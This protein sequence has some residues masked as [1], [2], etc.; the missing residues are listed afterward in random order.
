MFKPKMIENENNL[1]CQNKHG[2]PVHLVV[3]DPKL[4]K[5][6]RLLCTECMENFESDAKTIGFKKIIQIIEDNIK[7][8]MSDLEGI[9][10]QTVQ[11]LQICNRSIQELK[12]YFM[13][14]FDSLISIVEDWTQNLFALTQQSKQY[15]FYDELDSFI[16][17]QNNINDSNITLIN[18]INRSW[19]AKL[20][21]ILNQYIQDKD[22]VNFNEQNKNLQT[23][24]VQF[25]HKKVKQNQSQLINLLNKVWDVKIQFLIL[26]GQLWYQLNRKILKYGA[27]QTEKFNQQTY[28]DTTIRCWKQQDS[29]DWISSQPYKQHT[30]FVICLLLNSNEDLL[31][32]GSDDKLIKVWKVDF[33]QNILT[34]IY[35]LYQHYKEVFALS[36]NQSETL[37]VSCAGGDNEII[38]WERREQD[39][40]EFKNFVKQS[41]ECYGFKVKFIK[42]NQ[43]IWISG[44]KVI[45]K[46]YVF[47]LKEGIFQENQEKTIQLFRNNYIFDDYCFPIMYNQEKNLIIVRHKTHIY[48]FKEMKDGKFKILDYLNCNTY[49]IY[50]TITNNGQYLIYGM[51]NRK[52]FQHMNY[53]IHEQLCLSQYIILFQQYNQY[54]QV[55]I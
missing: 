30:D 51:I 47:E 17:K 14:L 32:S 8:T 36:L 1:H 24:F 5:K 28:C 52:D 6:Q 37:L 54:M 43:F 55:H 42:D 50:G 49:F 33:D 7:K 4:D 18:N 35:S 53:Q 46:F 2:Q 13:K 15:S 44:G 21:K 29:S 40:Y 3:L 27:F 23:S 11:Q 38:I 25:I 48:I 20:L 9:T 12:A 16:K 19:M 31:F 10:Q 34:Y 41:I 22:K 26:L 45:N 39:K